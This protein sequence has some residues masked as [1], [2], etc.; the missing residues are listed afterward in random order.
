MREKSEITHNRRQVPSGPG[1]R[2][3]VSPG[4]DG[5]EFP[6]AHMVAFQYAIF[7][8]VSG[9]NGIHD[10]G[11]GDAPA[12]SPRTSTHAFHSRRE[13]RMTRRTTPELTVRSV[14]G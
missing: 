3:C 8:T 2:A 7:Q 6:L 1:R 5:G 4:A 9:G 11:A 12:V 14:F 10:L 13:A